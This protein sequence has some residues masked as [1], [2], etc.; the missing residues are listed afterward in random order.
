[1]KQCPYCQYKYKDENASFCA[2]CGLRISDIDKPSEVSDRLKFWGGETRMLSAFFVNFVGLEGIIATRADQDLILIL[3]KCMTDIEDIIKKFNGTSNR[4]VPDNR[5]LGIFGAPKAH[6]DD[7]VKCLN[8][9]WNVRSWWLKR[10]NEESLLKDVDVTM[11]MNTGRAFFGYILEESAFLTVIGDT[12]NTAA[13]LTEMCPPNEILMSEDTYNRVEEYVHADHIGERSV[14][15]RAAKIDIFL[16]KEIKKPVRVSSVQKIPFCGRQ[17]ELKELIDIAEGIKQK[18][19]ELCII[20]GQMGIGKSRLKEEFEKY[21]SQNSGYQYY[22]THCSVD[23]IAPYFPFKFFLT[24]YFEISEY[25]SRDDI[26]KKISDRVAKKHM[27]PLTAKGLQHLFLTDM[28]RLKQDEMLSINEEIYTAV[29]NLVRVESKINPL[30]II[31]EEFNKADEMSRFLVSYLISELREEPIMLLLVNVS[32]DFLSNINTTIREINLTPLAFE[33]TKDLLVSLLDQVD[34]KLLQFMYKSAGGN[35]LFTIEAVRNTRRTKV[36]Q[37]VA[38]KWVIEKDQHLS[39]LDDLYGV[40]MSTID[41]LPSRYRLIVDYASVVG[42]SFS[43]RILQG[44]LKYE[45]LTEQLD[46]LVDEGYIIMSKRGEDPVYVFRH[47]LLKDAAYTVL[48][49]RKRKEI[50]RLVATLFER[51][52]ADQLSTFYENIA[53]HYLSCENFGKA[54]KY[55]ALAG[56]RAKNLYAIDQSLKF[57]GLVLE[58]DR[59]TVNIVPPDLVQSVL[60]NLSD[61]Y[62]INGDINKMEKTAERGMENARL[63]E[64]KRGELDFME[65][66]GYALCL[67]NRTNKA[68]ELLLTAVDSCED[69]MADIL[70]VLYSDLGVLYQIRNEYEKSILQYNSSWKTAQMHNIRKGEILCLLNLAKL[71]TNLGN[72][73]QAFEY[74]EHGLNNLIPKHDIRW[75]LYFKYETTPIMF[76]IWSLE[77]LQDSLEDCYDMSDSIGSIEIFLKSALDLAILHS[78]NGDLKKADEYIESAD[79]KVTFI[80]RDELL[81]EINYRKAKVNFYKS[82]YSKAADFAV[83]ALTLAQ[84]IRRRDIE[85][86]CFSLQSLLDSKQAYD[87]ARSALD[88]A[89]EIKIPPLI[90]DALFRMT[91]LSLTANDHEQARRYGRKALFIHDDIKSKLQKPRQQTYMKKPD[92]VKLLEL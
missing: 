69:G 47:N 41:S 79:S 61:I 4:I 54:A 85:S 48:P 25:D 37:K 90:A 81:T 3:R 49:M 77:Q 68:E 75:Q 52:Y 62:E 58:M 21:L 73:E 7:P 14:K 34:D 17:R 71:H 63:K 6:P 22:E 42:Y 33:E 45:G 15:G 29:K 56:D 66:Y 16:V 92:Y 44:L 28:K 11:G 67:L 35:P 1:M 43:Y 10:K 32:K 78:I 2:V 82:D 76:S 59:D 46:Y 19:A 53:H 12:I 31:F 24:R 84:K 39:F 74:L 70:A 40:V 27:S 57:Y 50:H 23:I 60:L 64:D 65:R 9:A 38:E 20:T 83:S 13:R 55:F 8:C 86:R 30:V 26:V 88:I 89:E 91:E 18:K 72:Y 36:I 5:V 87:H 80:I 51:L